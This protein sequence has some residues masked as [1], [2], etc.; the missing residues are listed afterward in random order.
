VRR[1]RRGSELPWVCPCSLSVLQ[2]FPWAVCSLSAGSLHAPTNC[3]PTA[4]PGTGCALAA[5]PA[6]QGEGCTSHWLRAPC[7]EKLPLST[8]PLLFLRKSLVWLLRPSPPQAP[9]PNPPPI[10]EILN[11]QAVG[12]LRVFS[13]P[14]LPSSYL[15]E[16][17]DFSLTEHLS[18]LSRTQ[19]ASFLGTTEQMVQPSCQTF[20][21]EGASRSVEEAIK[22]TWHLQASQLL[23][24][25]KY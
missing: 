12:A 15:E 3:L 7:K 1:W 10:Q 4:E 24:Q 8:C 19:T 18:V 14:H 6:E 9:H 25:C 13:N 23:S 16:C 20:T 22:D 11:S 17:R 2:L 5:M 21:K